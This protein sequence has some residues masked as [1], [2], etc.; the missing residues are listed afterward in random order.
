MKELQPNLLD[1]YEHLITRGIERYGGES[2]FPR[3]EAAG[4]TREQLDDFLFE[5][6]SALD[7]EGSQK[8]QLTKYGIVAILP[9][10]V[11]SA[12]PESMLPGRGYALY[13]SIG[14]GLLLALLWKGLS[15]LSVRHRINSLR[16]ANE[17]VAGY[18]DKVETYVKQRKTN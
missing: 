1:D 8:S 17:A 5:V 3:M 13:I 12:F 9:V 14:I 10:I 2:G 16:R 11:F 4:V 6:Q 15:V 7:S 18:A